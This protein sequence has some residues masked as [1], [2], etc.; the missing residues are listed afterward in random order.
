MLATDQQIFVVD[1]FSNVTPVPETN[2]AS[3]ITAIAKLDSDCVAVGTQDGACLILKKSGAWHIHVAFQYND[4]PIT[5]FAQIEGMSLAVSSED[6]KLQLVNLQNGSLEASEV[7][8]KT[9]VSTLTKYLK[10]NII[11]GFPDGR[12]KVWRKER[13]GQKVGLRAVRTLNTVRVYS[14][15]SV[16]FNAAHFL[17]KDKNTL[18]YSVDSSSLIKTFPV[19]ATGIT[20]FGKKI[21]LLATKEGKV[22]YWN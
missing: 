22:T 7:V 2:L 20:F 1:Q 9:Y 17:V 5:G 12:L 16:P 10:D 14:M 8:D 19:Q 15:L 13:N 6:R 3:P 4:G 18:V 11:C 21:L